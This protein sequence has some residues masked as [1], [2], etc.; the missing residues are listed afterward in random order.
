[1]DDPEFLRTL[2]L[3]SDL[4]YKGKE[5][6]ITDDELSIRST[7]IDI[8]KESIIKLSLFNKTKD[9]L[10][11]ILNKGLKVNNVL[12]QKLSGPSS[13]RI[14]TPKEGV[15]L[16]IIIML[17]DIHNKIGGQC[18]TCNSIDCDYK[19][20]CCVH[21]FEP[22]FLQLF[23]NLGSKEQPIEIFIEDYKNNLKKT[24]FLVYQMNYLKMNCE[25]MSNY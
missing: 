20:E 24:I 10:E 25:L 7:L 16:P 4:V 18:E 14:L 6:G 8:P 12:I 1:M 22:Y 5:N 3:G 23:D 11:T 17:G 9:S 15:D 13:L 2:A 19:E 21:S